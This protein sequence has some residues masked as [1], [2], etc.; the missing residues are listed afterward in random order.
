MSLLELGQPGSKL[1]DHH[2]STSY[3]LTASRILQLLKYA[4]QIFEFYISPGS[5]PNFGSNPTR[6]G[7][8][9]ISSRHHV[10]ITPQA[11]EGLQQGCRQVDPRGARACQG[12]FRRFANKG[13]ILMRVEQCPSR[14]RQADLARETSSP[15]T[16]LD[17]A[18]YLSSAYFFL[19][20]LFLGLGSCYHLPRPCRYCHYQQRFWRLG[21]VE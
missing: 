8:R 13:M 19:T 3:Y 12:L 1:L 14:H 20:E 18:R 15:G 16:K 11:R 4:G 5:S 17:E 7:R 9:S 21:S 6:I 10:R 2:R